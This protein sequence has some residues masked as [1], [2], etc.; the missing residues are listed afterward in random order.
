MLEVEEKIMRI[1]N[2][3]LGETTSIV[4]SSISLALFISFRTTDS[5]FMVKTY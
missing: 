5:K 2:G 4:L 3:E 1:L